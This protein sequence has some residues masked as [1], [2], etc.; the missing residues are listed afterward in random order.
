VV[1]TNEN[2]GVTGTQEKKMLLLI[3]L[4]HVSAQI[5]KSSVILAE[6]TNGDGLHTYIQ[7]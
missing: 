7:Y 2:G 1:L 3:D 6:Y 5:G 4:R